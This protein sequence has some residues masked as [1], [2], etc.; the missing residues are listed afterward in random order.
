MANEVPG[1]VLPPEILRRMQRASEKS[2]EHGLQ[3]GILI[4]REMFERVR[5]SVQG[6]QVSAPFGKVEFAL[7]VFDGIPGIRTDLAEQPP[8]DDDAFGFPPP[9]SDARQPRPLPSAGS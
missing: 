4:A 6:L 1:V 7:Q 8:L 2:R 3:E 5:A 9:A